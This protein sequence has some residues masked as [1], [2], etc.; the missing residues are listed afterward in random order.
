[1]FTGL[2]RITSLDLNR[3]DTSNVEDM[4]LMFKGCIELE[5]LSIQIKAQK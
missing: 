2:P 4:S 1:M 5:Y 3:F